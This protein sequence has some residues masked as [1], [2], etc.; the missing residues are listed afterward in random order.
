MFEIKLIV[1]LLIGIL[2]HLLATLV[3]DSKLY[4]RRVSIKEFRDIHPYQLPLS[5]LFSL[6]AYALFFELEQLNLVSAIA[7]GYMGDSI[8]K[9]AMNGVN[10]K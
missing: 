2:A 9:K 10:V 1:A 4:Q 3:E 8:V 6:M 7:A 5:I